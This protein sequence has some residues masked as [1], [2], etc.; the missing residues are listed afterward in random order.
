MDDIDED[1]ELPFVCRQLR[2]QRYREHSKWQASAVTKPQKTNRDPSAR[3]LVAA[4]VAGLLMILIMA[5]LLAVSYERFRTPLPWLLGNFAVG[6][7]GVPVWLVGLRK[8][9]F[10]ILLTFLLWA[11]FAMRFVGYHFFPGSALR[12]WPL[13]ERFQGATAVSLPIVAA[14]TVCIF[15]CME[16]LMGPSESETGESVN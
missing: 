4:R 13:A 6:L 3:W 14:T 2:A 8:R 16:W 10:W 12:G 1:L 5:T 9:N 15:L 11:N 7:I